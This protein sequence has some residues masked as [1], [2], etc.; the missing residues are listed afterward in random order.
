M[1]HLVLA[2]GRTQRDGQ[3]LLQ[4]LLQAGL[5]LLQEGML[6][7]PFSSPGQDE[8]RGITLPSALA[9]E[10]GAAPSQSKGTE[11]E[12]LLVAALCWWH[13]VPRCKGAEGWA[14]AS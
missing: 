2:A 6:Q 14:G 5:G 9:Q 13:K 1:M 12:F 10:R 3:Q 11:Q 7:E 8:G 4:H